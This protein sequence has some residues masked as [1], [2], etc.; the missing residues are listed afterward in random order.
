M[1]ENFDLKVIPS[2]VRNNNLLK[3]PKTN[4]SRHGT[5]ALCFKGSIIWNTVPN[6][7]KNLNSLDEFIQQIKMLKATTCTCKL[8]KVC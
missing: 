4:T 6:R 5:E 1:Q 7:Y 2:S 3:L 8:R